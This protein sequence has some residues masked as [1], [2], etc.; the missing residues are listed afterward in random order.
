MILISIEEKRA[1]V[2]QRPQSSRQLLVEALKIV[3]THLVHRDEH[4]QRGALLSRRRLL[5]RDASE[6]QRDWKNEEQRTKSHDGSGETVRR[7]SLRLR[8]RCRMRVG[9]VTRQW[10]PLVD[11]FLSGLQVPPSPIAAGRVLP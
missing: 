8:G 3:G 2:E 4:D 1:P 10:Y 7:G 5:R 11:P 6:E 9:L